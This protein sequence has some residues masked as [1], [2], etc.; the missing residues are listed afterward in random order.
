M[1]TNSEST[2]GHLQHPG[3][4]IRINYIASP[5]TFRKTPP[6]HA[7]NH[8]GKVSLTSFKFENSLS[9]LSLSLSF[10]L[11]RK[12][13]ERLLSKK[14]LCMLL[15]LFALCISWVRLC[16]VRAARER[17]EHWTQKCIWKLSVSPLVCFHIEH[18]F[19]A[20]Q[21]LSCSQSVVSVFKF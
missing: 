10:P 5:R 2:S 6:I 21:Y 3:P 9:F 14:N 16:K 8:R 18:F 19:F 4:L 1:S 20:A 13:F 12:P 7:K 11:L 15:L 17:R